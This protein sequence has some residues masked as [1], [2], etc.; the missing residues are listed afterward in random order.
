MNSF[1][2]PTQVLVLSLN[3]TYLF[4]IHFIIHQNSLQY[5]TI[6]TWI[7]AALVFIYFILFYQSVSSAK[8]NRLNLSK[9]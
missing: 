9:L 5:S 7:F 1:L 4:P 6:S 8:S 2:Y 3:L